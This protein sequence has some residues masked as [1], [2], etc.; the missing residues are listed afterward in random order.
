MGWYDW[1]VEN[2]YL[3]PDRALGTKVGSL[4]DVELPSSDGIKLGP[5]G[6]DPVRWYFW[7]SDQEDSGYRQPSNIDIVVGSADPPDG[8]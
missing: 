1:T 7:F 8:D 6:N 5:P 4:S 3:P 2:N